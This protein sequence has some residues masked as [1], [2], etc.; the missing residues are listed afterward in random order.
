MHSLAK[1]NKE[2]KQ[3]KMVNL[4]I[5]L[6]LNFITN[7]GMSLLAPFYPDL[8]KQ[9]NLD[10]FYVGLVFGVLNVG[11][12]I[13]AIVFGKMMM[14]W[15]RKL[16]ISIGLVLIC[17]TTFTYGIIKYIDQMYFFLSVSII[18]RL[19]QGVGC[20]AYSSIAYAYIPIL[21]PESIEEKI[22]YM[23][24]TT[25]LGYMLGPLIGTLLFMAGDYSLPF[26]VFTAIFMV[27][28][29]IATRLLPSDDRLK[30]MI[31]INK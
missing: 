10:V 28:T 27:S 24:V 17:L 19:I 18:A 30:Q 22:S 8:A 31:V 4:Y 2:G 26:Y 20:S 21:F 15:G 3:K 1:Q 25:G 29:P 7:S 13:S 5:L 16:I 23:E 6:V 11:A 12:F 14:A 9:K